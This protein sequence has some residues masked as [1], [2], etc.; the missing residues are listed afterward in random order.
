MSVTY[1]PHSG[2]R[3]RNQANIRSLQRIARSPASVWKKH[4]ARKSGVGVVGS[5]VCVPQAT[6]NKSK[7]GVRSFIPVIIV[8]YKIKGY[9]SPT[10]LILVCLLPTPRDMEIA[11]LLAGIASRFA[12]PR[13]F[14]GGTIWL[15]TSH[16]HSP[17]AADKLNSSPKYAATN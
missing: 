6:S 13:K 16:P 17:S 10:D 1:F 14:R 4:P 7:I 8:W 5:G 2:S 11:R 12:P 9:D 3:V 15:F